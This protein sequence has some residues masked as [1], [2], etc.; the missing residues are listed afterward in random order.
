MEV[1]YANISNKKIDVQHVIPLDI[2][3]ALYT[4]VLILPWK[5]IKKWALQST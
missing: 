5:K 4:I 3:Q 2:L 1:M